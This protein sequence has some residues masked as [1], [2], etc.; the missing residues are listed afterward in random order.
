MVWKIIIECDIFKRQNWELLSS[1]NDFKDKC[2]FKGLQP[3]LTSWGHQLKI[4]KHTF[5]TFA[6]NVMIRERYNDMKRI[7]HEIPAGEKKKWW[8]V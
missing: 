3:W 6:K 2:K 7:T 5:I 8:N 4:Q 1:T